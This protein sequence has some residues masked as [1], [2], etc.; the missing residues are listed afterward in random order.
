MF[1][2]K[3]NDIKSFPFQEYSK[4]NTSQSEDL[5][6][7]QFLTAYN[8]W[9]LPQINAHLA[10]WELQKNDAGLI[11]PQATAKHNIK[12]DWDIGLWRVIARLKRGSLVK[13]QSNPE[14][15]NYSALVPVILAAHKRFNGV[16]YPWCGIREQEHGRWLC[17]H[18]AC[19]AGSPQR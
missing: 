10:T 4:L 1:K 6:K 14:F 12:S 19:G 2:L 8:T 7:E 9:M 17:A 3:S 5:A 11:D 13:S 16:P 18:P 15:V